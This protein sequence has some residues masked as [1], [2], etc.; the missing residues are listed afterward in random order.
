MYEFMVRPT[1]HRSLLS[2]YT[3]LLFIPRT[4]QLGAGFFDVVGAIT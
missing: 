3:L 1:S 2:S 4:T